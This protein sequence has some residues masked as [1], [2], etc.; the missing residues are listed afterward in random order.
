MSLD[1]S[2]HSSELDNLESLMNGVEVWIKSLI[3][4][5]FIRFPHPSLS[6]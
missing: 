2:I 1:V 5:L 3:Q 6:C 4:S